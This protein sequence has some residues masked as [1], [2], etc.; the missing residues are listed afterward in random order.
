MK[1]VPAASAFYSSAAAAQVA[2]DPP[3]LASLAERGGR[4]TIVV[5]SSRPLLYHGRIKVASL[6]RISENT[7]MQYFKLVNTK[8]LT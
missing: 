6:I 1:E 8:K 5:G 2:M 7:M 4:S 3:S